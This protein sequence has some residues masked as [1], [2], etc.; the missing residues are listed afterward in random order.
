M[1]H[2]LAACVHPQ[3]SKAIGALRPG[4]MHACALF[5]QGN[6]GETFK[7]FVR[8]LGN[9]LQANPAPCS[10]C[11]VPNRKCM[12]R[13]CKTSSP[14]LSPVGVETQAWVAR[15]VLGV[16]SAL[17]GFQDLLKW[18]VEGIGTGGS[19]ERKPVQ[20]KLRN[21]IGTAETAVAFDAARSHAGAAAPLRIAGK[22]A[23]SIPMEHSVGVANIAYRR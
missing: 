4:S 7:G 9:G 16:G 19:L 6:A 3:P 23:A 2:P 14:N 18:I 21:R 17:G 5:S 12:P 22:L 10:T 13:G 15:T 1:A 8:P 11:S 20:R